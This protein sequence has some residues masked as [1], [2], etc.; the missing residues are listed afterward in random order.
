MRS[1]N[2]YIRPVIALVGVLGAI[3]VGAPGCGS[4]GEK[5]VVTQTI[6]TSGDQIVEGP[7][8]IDIKN[9]AQASERLKIEAINATNSVIDALDDPASGG[10]SYDEHYVG[11]KS[12]IVGPDLKYGNE[13]DAQYQHVPEMLLRYFPAKK[14]LLAQSYGAHDNPDTNNPYEDSSESPL[15][16]M[17]TVFK[18]GNSNPIEEVDGQ[19]TAKDFR[20]A[21]R[22]SVKLVA[23][24]ASYDEDYANHGKGDVEG[25]VRTKSG[26]E[27][28]GM[29]V[30]D[31]A[32]NPK[33]SK[34]LY[35]LEKVKGDKELAEA[36]S[37][38]ASALLNTSEMLA[39]DIQNKT[40]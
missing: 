17:A 40:P 28:N 22:G 25:V 13:D 8:E 1:P 14:L 24:W 16:S 4:D 32:L 6:T 30:I 29:D 12:A 3:G 2:Q 34:K 20:K 10:E 23:A 5:K 7:V 15:A 37:D 21:L 36:Y 18:V 38:T 33:S 31:Y 19:L 26:V 39:S 35:S 9:P 11:N 27:E